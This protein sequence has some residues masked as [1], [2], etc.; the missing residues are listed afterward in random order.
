M[1][2]TVCSTRR[3]VCVHLRREAAHQLTTE[4]AGTYGHIVIED[5]DVAAMKPGMGRRAFRRAVSDDGMGAIKPLLVYKTARCVGRLTVADRWFASSQIH[6]GCTPPDGAPCRLIGK[7][8]LDKKLVCPRTGE[9]VDRDANSALN[10]RD[11]PDHASCGPVRTTAPS[12]PGPTTPLVGT[13]HGDDAGTPDAAGAS[14][15]PSRRGPKQRGQNPN[16]ARGRRMSVSPKHTQRQRF[17]LKRPSPC[18]CEEGAAQCGGSRPSAGAI[19]IPRI[20]P[21]LGNLGH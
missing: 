6:H 20:Q 7:G 18:A 16:P 4:L 12:V 1:S 3:S 19:G 17:R 8:K 2:W 13:G 11:W 15:R 5:L 14:V 21:P 9:L 10:L